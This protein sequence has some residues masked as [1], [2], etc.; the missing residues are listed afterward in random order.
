[1]ACGVT[2]AKTLLRAVTDGKALRYRTSLQRTRFGRGNNKHNKA[3]TVVT[4]RRLTIVREKHRSL[5]RL[6]LSKC[7]AQKYPFAL[8]KPARL[9]QYCRGASTSVILSNRIIFSKQSIQLHPPAGLMERV[10]TTHN[11]LQS[12]F[13]TYHRFTP[14]IEVCS[15]VTRF[16]NT[17]VWCSYHSRSVSFS[18]TNWTLRSGS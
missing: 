8:H 4:L 3:I 10:Y 18:R 7:S 11:L 1:M 14:K 13:H 5:V 15:S 16:V 2:N 9:V 12:F 6:L 17:S